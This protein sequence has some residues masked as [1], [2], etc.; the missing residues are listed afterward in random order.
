MATDLNM[1]VVS[2]EYRLAPDH[3]F[4]IPM[5]DCYDA[6]LHF[7]ENAEEFGVDPQRI[8]LAGWCNPIMKTPEQALLASTRSILMLRCDVI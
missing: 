5:N 8:A 2:V 1:L 3:P 4:P 7:L 6:T